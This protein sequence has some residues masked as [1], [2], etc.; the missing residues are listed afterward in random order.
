VNLSV[1]QDYTFVT[2]NRSDFLALYRRTPL[3]AALVIIVPNVKPALQ[4]QLF[5]TALRLISERD[6]VNTVIEVGYSD[7]QIECHQ[8]PLSQGF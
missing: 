8:Y 7:K 1:E 6:L 2:N 5:E 3:H 4:R